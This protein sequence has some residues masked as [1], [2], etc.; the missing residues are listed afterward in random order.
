MEKHKKFF[1]F[2]E[3]VAVLMNYE[4]KVNETYEYGQKF[5][6]V[7]GPHKQMQVIMLRGLFTNWKQ[8]I[9]LDFD[10]SITPEIVSTAIKKTQSCGFDVVAC[11]SDMGGGNYGMWKKMSVGLDKPWFANPSDTS[12]KV[13]M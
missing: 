8:Q 6:Q 9:F 11:V 12:K 1:C 13:F 7:I 5:D 10:T 2:V 3:K 4:I